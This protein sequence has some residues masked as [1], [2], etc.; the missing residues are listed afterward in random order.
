MLQNR[1]LPLYWTGIVSSGC[2]YHGGTA[3][4]SLYVPSCL[5]GYAFC[6]S[7]VIRNKLMTMLLTLYSLIYFQPVDMAWAGWP[8][9]LEREFTDRKVRCLNPTSAPRLP[10]LCLGNLAVS[11][12]SC[13]ILVAWQ[14]GTERV[15]QLSDFFQRF[16]AGCPT[17]TTLLS[18]FRCS[19]NWYYK[20]TIGGEI[21]QRLERERTDRKVRGSNPASASR[22]PLSRL[23]QPGSIP[24]LVL[25]SG[26]MAARHRKGATAERFFFIIHTHLKHALSVVHQSLWLTSLTARQRRLVGNASSLPFLW[27][28]SPHFLT[29]NLEEGPWFEPDLCLSNIHDTVAPFR[30]L[31]AML[32]EGSI[33]AGILPGCPSLDRG[34]QEA[35]VGSE[36]RTFLS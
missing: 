2:N 4:Y 24:A 23:G 19:G 20:G 30:C 11:Q 10:R 21:A 36:P 31:T 9:W 1:T 16:Y 15:L 14:S 34:S 3:D 8:K 18:D 32:P 17:S 27:N 12:L 5:L 29:P 7:I 6:T 33:R 25:P 26:G 22:L 35:D 28:K 13:F